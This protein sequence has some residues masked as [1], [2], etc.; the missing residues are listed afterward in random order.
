MIVTTDYFKTPG[1]PNF[2]PGL[3][4][5]NGIPTEV[6]NSAIA[7]VTFSINAYETEYLKSVL[8]EELYKKYVSEIKD[9]LLKAKWDSFVAQLKDETTYLSPIA[10]YIYVKHIYNNS[11]TF[12]GK[13]ATLGTVSQSGERVPVKLLQERAWC[14]MVDKNR[15]FFGW[16]F[17]NLSIIDPDGL[18]N[19]DKWEN[20]LTYGLI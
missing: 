2:I 15:E 3:E 8:G 16:V 13:G 4:V 14:N 6:G 18:I 12:N 17:N 9:D 1:H 11:L 7:G 19:I 5:N 20:L 10:D